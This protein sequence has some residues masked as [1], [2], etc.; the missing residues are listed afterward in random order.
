MD[1]RFLFATPLWS[2]RYDRVDQMH[3]WAQHILRLEA[4]DPAGL[5]L[6]NQGGWHSSTSLL[7]DPALADLFRWIAQQTQVALQ[8]F[9]WDLSKAMPSF[10]NAWAMVNRGSHS[11]R[12]HL[13]PN[14]LF[15]GVVYL[16][17]PPGSGSIAFLDP[18]A[19]AQMLMPPLAQG[20]HSLAQGRVRHAPREGELLLFPSWLWHEVEPS[21][22]NLAEPRICIS[23]NLGMKLATT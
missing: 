20:E 13:H 21:A 11:V 1:C 6:T 17:L 16:A 19:G 9:G 22:T 14:S 15:S 10:N 4:E 23:F 3:H 5:Q 12:A 7:L 2:C 18:R 8:S